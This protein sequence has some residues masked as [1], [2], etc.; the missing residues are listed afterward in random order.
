MDVSSTQVAWF[1]L[2]SYSVFASPHWPSYILDSRCTTAHFCEVFPQNW[3]STG[4]KARR[5][6]NAVCYAATKQCCSNDYCCAKTW[7]PSASTLFLCPVLCWV[8]KALWLT[9]VGASSNFWPLALAQELLIC[10]PWS[11]LLLK[12]CSDKDC[13]S[14]SGSWDFSSFSFGNHS[15]L[16][17]SLSFSFEFLI[18]SYTLLGHVAH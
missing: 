14:F 10:Y 18:L 15:S 3:K 16:A 5:D 11:C 17:P 2:S 13:K 4:N 6:W 7:W 1:L 9:D 12:T 8:L